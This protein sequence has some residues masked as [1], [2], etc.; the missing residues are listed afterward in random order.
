MAGPPEPVLRAACEALAAADPALARAYRE[1]GL[2][3]WRAAPAD[4]ATL[5]RLITHQQISVTAARAIWARFQAAFDPI[6]P[7]GLLAA[8]PDEIRA[9]GLSRPKT[10]H[11]Q[12]IAHAIVAGDLVLDRVA[13]A[14]FDEARE[15]LLS[16]SGIGPWTADLFL[17]YATNALDA[18]PVADIGLTESL[19]GLTGAETRM[20]KAA[21]AERGEAWRP[22]RGVAAH[23]LWAWISA[24]REKQGRA[25]PQA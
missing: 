13:A 9:C 18:F 23:L 12:S 3:V 2:P 4:Y 17:L 24:E 25:S 19:R 11:L 1:T 8:D 22:Y 10:R 5:C 21:F 20:D 7:E 15:E 14:S 16:V 6:T